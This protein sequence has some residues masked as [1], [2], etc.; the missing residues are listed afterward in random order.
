[1]NKVVLVIALL[2][3]TVFVSGCVEQSTIKSDEQ[4]VQE[5]KN[6]TKGVSD[7][8]DAFDDIDNSLTGYAV[9]K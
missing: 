3:L 2:V 4:A 6:L 5:V 7:L 1:M 9:N 8:S